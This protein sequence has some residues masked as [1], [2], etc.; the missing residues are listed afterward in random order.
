MF[1]VDM[2]R[3]VGT[4]CCSHDSAALQAARTELLVHY[5]HIAL[6]KRLISTV[7]FPYTQSAHAFMLTFL[8]GT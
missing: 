4:P 8:A 5:E 7:Q 3:H 2:G 6:R 1:A